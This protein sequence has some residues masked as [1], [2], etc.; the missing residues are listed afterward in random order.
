[1]EIIMEYLDPKLVALVVGLYF[2]GVWLK[3]SS[4]QDKYIPLVLG[5]VG[6]ALTSMWIFATSPL[7]TWQN[8]VIAAFNSIIQGILAAAVSVYGN[9]IYKQLTS[10]TKSDKEGL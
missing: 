6:I 3:K 8:A 9:Q 2:L 5:G 10:N 7:D 1:M 4:M